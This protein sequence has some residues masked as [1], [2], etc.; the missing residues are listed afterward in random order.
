M[1]L[2]RI[3]E[4][5]ESISMQLYTMVSF[6]RTFDSKTIE[7]LFILIEMH[8]CLAI[9]TASRMYCQLLFYFYLG[10]SFTKMLLMTIF[11]LD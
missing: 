11:E 9:F 3:I 4:F 7:P 10:L 8:N 6:Q 2:Y 1:C 5:D